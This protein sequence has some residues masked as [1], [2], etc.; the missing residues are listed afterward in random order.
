MVKEFKQLIKVQFCSKTRATFGTEL[1]GSWCL[2]STDTYILPVSKWLLNANTCQALLCN[3][4][5]STV[6]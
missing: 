6:I 5:D 3:T 2:C 4:G 1:R